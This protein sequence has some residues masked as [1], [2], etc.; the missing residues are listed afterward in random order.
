MKLISF[1]VI[2]LLA[3]TVNAQPPLSTSADKDVIKQKIRDLR[4]THQEQHR[5][6]FE[7]REP[8]EVEQEKHKILSVMEEIEKELKRTDL[9]EGEKPSLE[10]HYTGSVNDL[11]KAGSALIPKQQ[12]LDEAV[13]QSYDAVIKLLILKENLKRE[14]EQSVRDKSK[15]GAS[16]SL[17]PHR[18]I[19]Q[20]QINEGFQDA[21]DL[22]DADD[23][24]EKGTDKLDDMI[25]RAKN[26]KKNKLDKIHEKLIGSRKKLVKKTF[27]SKHWW[28]RAKDL[29]K[30]F[31]WSSQN[32]LVVR[33]YQ[34]FW[35]GC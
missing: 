30:G 24:I 11:E 21:E 8:S 23:D 1:A 31:G 26:S 10:G 14:A 27:F 32:S 4:A 3:I 13:V 17:S 28:F 18:D 2:A 7:L 19:L 15:T 35:M 34:S 6:V 20:K 22:F 33:L 9:L 16:S 25:K 12:Q 29:Q 5:L